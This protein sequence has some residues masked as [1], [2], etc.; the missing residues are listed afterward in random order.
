MISNNSVLGLIFSNM[1]DS[2]IPTLTKERTMGSVMFGGRYRLIDFPLSNLV[3]SGVAEIGVIT[4]SNYQSLLDHIGSGR[5]WDLSNKNGGLHL[6][7]PFSHVGS[8]IYRG[9]IEAL[10]GVWRFVEHSNAEFVIMTDCDVATTIDYRPVLKQHIETGADITAVYAKMLKKDS[11]A[12]TGTVFNMNS[13][14]RITDVMINPEILGE[15]NVSLNMYVIKK[16]FLRNIVKELT[17]KGITSFETA[18]LQGQKDSI[19]IYAYEHKDYFSKID[20]MQSYYDENM[21]L[22]DSEKRTAL[23]KNEMPIYTKIRDNGPVKYGINSNVK[24]SLIADGCIIEGTVENSVLFRGVKVGKGAV[25]KNCILMQDTVIGNNC[26]VEAIV[27]DKRAEI[28]DGRSLTG[29]KSYPIYVG[30]KAV[31]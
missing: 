21:A 27:T 14:G 20:S 25:V 4:K 15:F 28:T 3:N 30:K 31:I 2:S 11:E 9:R 29:S 1:H 5:E 12:V 18:V 17:S 22:L 24:N 13:E 7:P 19:K 26:E 8:G 6:L 10:S 16:D 23:F